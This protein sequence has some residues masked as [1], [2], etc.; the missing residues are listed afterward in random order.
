MKKLVL[1]LSFAVL[2]VGATFA[3]ETK[4]EA[5][6]E[7]ASGFTLPNIDIQKVDGSTFNSKDFDNGGKPIII[8]FWATW[9]KPCI[10]EL[11]TI[12]E[13]Y[14]A[15]QKET[16]VKLIAISVD[17]ERTKSNAGPYAESNEWLYEVYLDP[18][19]DFQRAMGVIN[20]PHTFL[21]DGNKKV[22]FQHTSYAPGDEKILYAELKKL[23]EAKK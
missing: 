5:K 10:R 13:D 22:V 20:V 3:Q 15:W 17:D 4:A 6:H 18:N 9:C 12:Q 2:F 21:L 14:E 7:I 23:L 19:A 1:F 8:S 11:N 16:G